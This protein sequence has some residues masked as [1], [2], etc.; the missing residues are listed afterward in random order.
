[1]HLLTIWFGVLQRA[2]DLEP[3]HY[4]GALKHAVAIQFGVLQRAAA[5][6]PQH[7]LGALKHAE[8]DR[9]I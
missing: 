3:Q 5:L 4:R 6:E 9:V 7:Y 2:A 1:M 8:P